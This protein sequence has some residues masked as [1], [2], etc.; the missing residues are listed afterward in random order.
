MTAT[1]SPPANA[2]DLVRAD[3][4]VR[5][6]D[7]CEALEFYL[8]LPNSHIDRIIFVENSNSDL[9]ALFELCEREKHGKQIEFLAF[10]G[11]NDFP[12]EYG[13][14]YGEMI[15]LNYA[16]DKTKL[17]TDT[18]IVWKA[19][20][21]LILRNLQ[22]LIEG[23]PNRYKV[24]CDLHDSFPLL[25]LQ[26]FFD[27]RFFSF[28][29]PGYETYFRR[30]P[31]ELERAHIEHLYFDVL[32]AGVAAGDVK[33]RFKR[34]PIILGYNAAQGTNYFTMKKRVQRFIQQVARVVAPS[35]WL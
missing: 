9:T 25:S 35:V 31:E 4:T 22:Q 32:K 34:Q 11:G 15:M 2:K 24:Y 3:P 21:R 23:A 29:L 14:G 30:K 1:I 6:H 17:F 10:E 20:G 26:H 18:D 33:P 7:Y 16:I 19:T 12:P 27:P 28:T 13:K 8:R 5:L